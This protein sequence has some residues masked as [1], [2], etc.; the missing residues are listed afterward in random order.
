M[1]FNPSTNEREGDSSPLLPLLLAPLPPLNDADWNSRGRF[2]ELPLLLLLLPMP[3]Y[4]TPYAA[5]G[6]GSSRRARTQVVPASA[7]LLP[8]L[9]LVVLPACA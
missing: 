3:E 9:L 2:I 1:R 6:A 7:G 4:R 8:L 5:A